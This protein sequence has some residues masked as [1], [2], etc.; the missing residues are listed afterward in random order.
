MFVFYFVLWI[1][2]NGAVTT[3]IVLFGLGVSALIYAFTCKFMGFSFE[4]DKE[5]VRRFFLFIGYVFVLIWEVIKANIDMIKLIVVRHEEELEPAV[6]KLETKL[7]SK[8]CRTILAN[9]ITLTPGTITVEMVDNVLIIHA[10]DKS[11]IIEQDADFI[12][13]RLL[14]KL[15][16]GAKK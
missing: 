6:F 11:I 7:K 4:K 9:S 8:V 2:F 1:I 13:E 12:F 16:G 14:L 10:V 15:E 3:E 5:L